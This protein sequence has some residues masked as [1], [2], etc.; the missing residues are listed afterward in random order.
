MQHPPATVAGIGEWTGGGRRPPPGPGEETRRKPSPADVRRG[1]RAVAHGPADQPDGDQRGGVV[2]RA[3]GLGRPD[4]ARRIPV[5]RP[6][7][8][9]AEA[10]RRGTVAAAPAAVGERPALR[11]GKPPPPPC[12][13]GTG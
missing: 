2:R 12:A 5:G 13:A 11:A 9:V 7:P 4:E 3:A 10:G 1:Y 8:A 6:V